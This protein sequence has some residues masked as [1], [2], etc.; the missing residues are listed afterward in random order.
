MR[1]P[2]QGWR[3]D[4]LPAGD[5]LILCMTCRDLEATLCHSRT[6]S[7][8]SYFCTKNRK[9]TTVEGS[10]SASSFSHSCLTKMAA[11]DKKKNIAFFHP[12][13]GIGGAERLIIDAAVGLKNRGHKV[14]IFTSHCDPKHCFDEARDGMADVSFR[15]DIS[16]II[17]RH[18]RCTSSRQLA[19]S[20][21]HPWSIF[22]HMRN[23]PTITP[24]S[25]DILYIRNKFIRTQRLRC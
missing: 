20:S 25:L 21:F 13:L 11:A 8:Y 10:L 14:V 23:P 2:A 1:L 18:S 9:Q 22:H 3:R 5:L 17:C 19:I 15:M 24:H 16:D 6:L 4:S 7:A 12:D